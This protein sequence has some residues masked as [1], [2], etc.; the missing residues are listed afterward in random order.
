[1]KKVYEA[2][3][4]CLSCDNIVKFTGLKLINNMIKNPE[5]RGLI[6]N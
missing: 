6:T 3:K 2:L 4:D 1:M 5:R